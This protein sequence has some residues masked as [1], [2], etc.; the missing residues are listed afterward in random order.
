MTGDDTS[1]MQKIHELKAYCAS[2]FK[3]DDPI[4]IILEGVRTPE[5]LQEIIPVLVRKIRR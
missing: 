5:E 2:N 4:N 1:Q 3:A